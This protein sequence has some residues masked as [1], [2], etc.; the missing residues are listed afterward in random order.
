MLLPISLSF[1]L[2][3]FRVHVHG[4]LNKDQSHK[5]IQQVRLKNNNSKFMVCNGNKRRRVMVQKLILKD[6]KLSFF[7]KHKRK[8]LL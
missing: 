6:L 1:N 3:A 8:L 4:N 7:C 5:S 2:L